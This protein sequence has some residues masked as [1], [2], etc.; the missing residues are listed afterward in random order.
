M[1]DY[2]FMDAHKWIWFLI[3]SE[4]SFHRLCDPV[5]FYFVIHAFIMLYY[6]CLLSLCSLWH[7]HIWTFAVFICS[8]NE[9][10]CAHDTEANLDC[11]DLSKISHCFLIVFN[12]LSCHCC[13]LVSF[14]MLLLNCTWMVVV[15]CTELAMTDVCP[16]LSC[17]CTFIRN[18]SSNN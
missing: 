10:L 3:V 14:L 11:W 12:Y 5:L 8:Q 13:L 16:T 4:F 17:R 15:E 7:V 9:P 2:Y 6:S 1:D 18:L